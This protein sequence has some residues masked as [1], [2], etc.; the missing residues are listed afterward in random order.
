MMVE[1]MLIVEDQGQIR[2]MLKLALGYGKYVMYEAETGEE[3][4]ATFAATQPNVVLLDVMLPGNVD[5]FEVCQWIR[6]KTEGLVY[7]PYIVMI[8]AKQQ[9]D[10]IDTGRKAGADVYVIKPFSPIN[11]IEVIESRSEHAG[12]MRIIRKPT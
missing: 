2:S 11:L 5:G 3:A 10:D 8:T 4:M 7:K 6:K 9:N 1:K 12:P